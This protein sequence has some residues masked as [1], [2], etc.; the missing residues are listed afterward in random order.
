MVEATSLEK[1]LHSL[2]KK[3][4][5]KMISAFDELTLEVSSKKLLLILKSLRDWNEFHF[6]QLLDVAGVDYLEYEKTEWKT[7]N[8]TNSGFSRGVNKNTFGRFSFA[9]NEISP[10]MDQPRYAVVYHLLSIKN[11]IRLRVKCFCDDNDFP[12]MPSACAIWSAANWYEREAFDL[13]GIVFQGH[14]DMRRLLTDYGFVGH[15]LR[16]DFPLVGHVETR[17]DPVKKRVV[18]EPV[19]IEPRVLVPKVI[20]KDSRYI[21]DADDNK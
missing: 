13:F 5:G 8:A 15:P 9:D 21:T 19:S 12:L 14:P 4:Q 16:K 7:Q 3:H 1:S 17:Y 10:K 18:Y 20:R 11:N 2:C 6:E